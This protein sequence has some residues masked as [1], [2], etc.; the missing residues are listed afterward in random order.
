MKNIL[1][2]PA[3]ISPCP[4][5]EAIFECRYEPK[6]PPDTIFGI[7]YKQFSD[8]YPKLENLPILQ[9]PQQIRLQD[10]NLRYQPYYRMSS[11]Q[12]ILSIGPRALSLSNI[13]EY[14]GWRVFYAEIKKLIEIVKELDIAKKIVRFSLRYINYFNEDILKKTNLVIRM[15][16]QPIEAARTLVRLDIK[17]NDFNNVIQISNDAELRSKDKQLHGSVIDIDTYLEDIPI[18]LFSD[19]K[20]MLSNCHLSEKKV[21]FSLLKRDFLKSL[22]PVYEEEL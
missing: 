8:F 20:A 4:I 1:Q 9:I 7:L 16:K 18:N 12:F 14:V 10:S 3:K 22:N 17:A 6:V 19:Y 15:G 5:I 13:N 2:L 11:E 21:F